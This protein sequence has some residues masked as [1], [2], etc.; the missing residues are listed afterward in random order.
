MEM[1]EQIVTWRAGR[2]ANEPRPPWLLAIREA[3]DT[4]GDWDAA[5]TKV[6]G[7]DYL[8]LVIGNSHWPTGELRVHYPPDGGRYVELT[9]GEYTFAEV[10]VPDPADWLPFNAAYIEPYL[11]TRATL[12]NA[13]RVER[14][15]NAIIAFARHGEGRHVERETGESLIDRR[16]DAERYR[17][18]TTAR[19]AAATTTTTN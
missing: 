1:Q 9:E 16:E 19:R 18:E 7:R 2:F 4:A 8:R 15:A 17:R 14:L 11:L 6:L 12:H 10:W 5:V 3:A 13:E